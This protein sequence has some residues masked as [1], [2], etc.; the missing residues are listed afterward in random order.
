[1][2]VLFRLLFA[3]LTLAKIT[4]SAYFA[5][6]FALQF[7]SF[8]PKKVCS[9]HM[10]SIG[11]LQLWNIVKIY[12]ITIVKNYVYIKIRKDKILGVVPPSGRNQVMGRAADILYIL[13]KCTCM[14]ICSCIYVSCIMYSVCYTCTIYYTI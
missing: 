13:S 9:F 1:M 3:F 8:G 10:E 12:S 4:L 5:K 2:F 11:V 14:Y 7:T 6:S